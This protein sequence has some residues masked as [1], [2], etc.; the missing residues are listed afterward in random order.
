VRL[1]PGEPLRVALVYAP[2]DEVPVG[3]LALDRGRAVF[4][5]GEAFIASGKALNPLWGAPNRTLV[6]AQDP[7]TFKGLHGVFA[8]SLPDAWGHELM[9]RRLAEQKVNY[10]DLTALDRLALV[11]SAGVG[12]L[13]YRPDY[14]EHIDGALDIGALANGAIELDGTSTKVVEE[15]ARLGGSSG[16]ARPKVLVAR[17][18]A[19]DLIAGTGDVPDGYEPYIVKFRGSMDFVDIGPLEAAYADMARAA[20]VDVAPT[21]LIPATRG[22]GYFATRRFDRGHNGGRIPM[23]SVAAVIE[24]DWRDAAIDYV[25]L[26]A[27]VGSITRDHEA[28]EQLFRRMVFNV[29]AAN[30]DDH[31][32]QHS[33]L[34]RR[35]GEWTLAPAYDLTLSSGP[36]GH[37]YLAVNNK[38]RD[39]TLDDIYAVARETS[40]KDAHAR[41]IVEDVRAAVA[42][43][44]TIAHTYGVTPATMT[45]FKRATDAFHAAPL[46]VP[47]RASTHPTRRKRS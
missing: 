42:D 3:R 36:N 35:T 30:A 6:R 24:A 33:F 14:A 43:F 19:G 21:L 20:G 27:L 17:N 31:T 16:G 29:L 26:I 47:A 5:Y 18:A 32:K 2:D 46:N 40:I 12:A 28:A 11:G 38:G 22:H 4:E 39:I 44:P 23:L 8:D 13:V 7:R 37:R 10:D 41:A 15:L 34:Q 45:A 25:K 9:R 1:R